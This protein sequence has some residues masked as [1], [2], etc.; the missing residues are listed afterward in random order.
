M[1]TNV[2]KLESCI[3]SSNNS[4]NDEALPGVLGNRAKRAFIS[5]EHGNK[6]QILGNRRASMMEL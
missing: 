1:S 2:L 5:G 6:G 4:N 3:S